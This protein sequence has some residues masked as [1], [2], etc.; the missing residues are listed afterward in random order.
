ME[1]PASTQEG[2][3]EQKPIQ[4]QWESHS[5]RRRTSRINTLPM[6][7]GQSL[8]SSLLQHPTH[9]AVKYANVSEGSH[10]TPCSELK[11]LSGVL[12]LS[13]TKKLLLLKAELGLCFWPNP[14]ALHAL[15]QGKTYPHTELNPRQGFLLDFEAGAQCRLWTH[16]KIQGWL[17]VNNRGSEAPCSGAIDGNQ[18]LKNPTAVPNSLCT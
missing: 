6:A 14:G 11:K 17:S 1:S 5:P 15:I 9:F 4:V 2:P 3:R 7:L 10:P 8:C 12:L 18:T 16:Q 13:L